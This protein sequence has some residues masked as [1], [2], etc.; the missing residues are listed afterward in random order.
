MGFLSST[1]FS[2]TIVVAPMGTSETMAA[3]AGDL[4]LRRYTDWAVVRM[5]L[6]NQ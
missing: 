3:R 6:V 4:N 5:L 1:G 2:L